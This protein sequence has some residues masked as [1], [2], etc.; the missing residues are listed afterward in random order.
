MSLFNV[1]KIATQ[2]IR[3]SHLLSIAPTGTISYSADNI[4]SGIEPV[5]AHKLERTVIEPSGKRE[6]SLGDYGA[7]HLGVYGKTAEECSV[8]DHLGVLITASK[9]VDSAVSK[10]CNLPKNIPW[11]DF[12]DVYFDAWQ[13]GCKGITTYR[14]GG[15]KEGILKAVEESETLAIA[16]NSACTFDPVTGRKNCE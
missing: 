16:D 9:Y 1:Y 5:F 8:A 12:K 10:T 3:N 4:S 14:K 15:Q 13:A 11:E 7:A 6:V 2:G